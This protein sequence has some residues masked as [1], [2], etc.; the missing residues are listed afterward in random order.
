MQPWVIAHS[1]S[2]LGWGGQEIRVFTEMNAFRQ[3]GHRLLLAA[4]SASGILQKVKE[5][6]FE[7]CAFE[8]S[9][10][11]FPSAVVR[12]TRFFRRH[13]VQVVNT[14][15]SRDGWIAGL[16][17]RLAGVPLLIRSRHI[18]VDYPNRFFSRLAFKTLPHHVITT[19]QRISARLIEELQL[20][21]DRVSCVP[22]GIDLA[23]FNPQVAGSLHQELGL[24]RDTPLVGMIS[25]LRSW[26][27]HYVFI[28]AITLLLE[29]LPQARFIIA[30][31][32]TKK[33][34]LTAT[35]REAGLEK[36]ILMIGHR[37]DVPGVL[38]SLTALVLPS[39]AHEGI[40]QIILQA[41]AVGTPVIGTTVGGIP[42]VVR[43]EETGLLIPPA[44]PKALAEAIHRLLGDPALRERIRQNALAC[45]QHEHGLERMCERLEA[46]Y[47]RYLEDRTAA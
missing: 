31:T 7:V 6:G 42:E 9:P 16:A 1:E 19:S 13:A 8:D 24:P 14:H 37:D 22:T 12:L 4:P 17:A 41:Q 26:K 21:S 20:P 46:I 40:P 43:H 10:A 28:D 11:H 44:D 29:K 39:T 32:G 30:G 2:S 15:S 38:A 47:R 18:E 33:D 27:G 36:R 3:H 25:V 5:A 35:I 34:R 23:R 45:A